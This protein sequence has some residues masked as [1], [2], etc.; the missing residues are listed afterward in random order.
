MAY[1]HYRM[2]TSS[3]SLEH[4]NE[5]LESIS[6]CVGIGWTGLTGEPFIFK[7]TWDQKYDFYELVAYANEC[8]LT[9]W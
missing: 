4:R 3:M 1:K 8:G 7:L 9:P 2:D 6:R 5:L